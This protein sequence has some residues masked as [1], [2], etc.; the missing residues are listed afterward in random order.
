[1]EDKN[2]KYIFKEYYSVESN[3]LLGICKEKWNSYEG[4]REYL[5][6]TPQCYSSIDSIIINSDEYYSGTLLGFIVKIE[7]KCG[8]VNKE[9]DI[10][11]PIQYDSIAYY[12]NHSDFLHVLLDG[13][14]GVIT[15]DGT[16]IIPCLYDNIWKQS[17]NFF[18]VFANDK[19]GIYTVKGEL[20]MPVIYDDIE[21][22]S[23]NN[24]ESDD[25]YFIV[26][27]EGQYEIIKQDRTNYIPG[28]FDNCVLNYEL[29]ICTCKKGKWTL[30]DTKGNILIPFFDSIEEKNTWVRTSKSHPY[31]NYYKFYIDNNIGLF[32]CEKKEI[33][34]EAF[35]DNIEFKENGIIVSQNNKKGLYNFE[36]NEIVAP[37]FQS[38]EY[39]ANDYFI[40]QNE[41]KKGLVWFSKKKTLPCIYEEIEVY[42]HYDLYFTIISSG[43][44]GLIDSNLKI[45]LSAI[46]D[47]FIIDFHQVKIRIDN[48]WGLYNF[49][50]KRIV[51]PV[52]YSSIEN[53][54]SSSYVVVK[55]D[56]LIGIYSLSGNEKLPVI[57]HDIKVVNICYCCFYII[58]LD[59]QFGVLNSSMNLIVPCKYGNIEFYDRAFIIGENNNNKTIMDL[60]GNII[61]SDIIAFKEIYS[62]KNINSYYKDYLTKNINNKIGIIHHGLNTEKTIIPVNYIKAEIIESNNKNVFYKVLEDD[63]WGLFYVNT[64]YCNYSNKATYNINTE[65]V[66]P[67]KFNTIKHLPFSSSKEIEYFIVSE[68]CNYGV[69]EIII[70]ES[71]NC[72]IILPCKF[73][74]IRLLYDF[75]IAKRNQKYEIYNILGEKI[76]EQ[77]FNSINTIG[78]KYIIG[79]TDQIMGVYLNDGIELFSSYFDKIEEYGYS[80]L[81]GFKVQKYGLWGLKSLEGKDIIPPLYEDIKE[82]KDEYGNFLCHVAQ[83]KGQK[84]C[85]TKK[86]VKINDPAEV[87]EYINCHH[88]FKVKANG[89]WGLISYWKNSDSPTT[90][91]SPIYDSINFIIKDDNHKIIIVNKYNK[92]GLYLFTGREICPL[93]IDFIDE[94]T[95]RNY[96]LKIRSGNKYGIVSIIDEKLIVPIK[97]DKIRIDDYLYTSLNNLHGLYDFDGEEICPTIY[98]RIKLIGHEILVKKNNLWGVLNFLPELFENVEIHRLYAKLKINKFSNIKQI[99]W[100]QVQNKGEILFLFIYISTEKR[101]VVYNKEGIDINTPIFTD[102]I[103]ISNTIAL[104]INEKWGVFDYNFNQKIAPSYQTI[105][106]TFL[107]ID[108]G[109]I[110]K[111][112]DCIIVQDIHKK[113]G[114]INTNGNII[115]P[116]IYDYLVKGNSITEYYGRIDDNRYNLDKTGKLIATKKI[117]W[118]NLSLGYEYG[119]FE[120][121][122]NRKTL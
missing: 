120:D 38:I 49:D 67:C 58:R 102:F 115:I 113:Y 83:I 114:C 108:N 41:S 34:L 60:N 57:Y 103:F 96:F 81:H 51:I 121:D 45:I 6:I 65:V 14:W 116:F 74:E 4:K 21:I 97:Y 91:I 110:N 3:N 26:S 17:N 56:K 32:D 28:K 55:L 75:L 59:N 30:Y 72:K 93:T 73:E 54:I 100:E 64:L 119:I 68:N 13:K 85:Y 53:I 18:F 9:G 19:E 109:I 105:E 87:I 44:K 15:F 11:I 95:G 7:N 62:Y 82:F 61:E 37:F 1:M 117:S 2:Y 47:E 101:W 80:T 111:Y 46:Y 39:I 92:Y 20:I 40:I 50:E 35:Y 63:R 25:Y 94:W 106:T 23:L 52:H 24:G 48:K 99:N 16:S 10:I 89:L 76:I 27:T 107:K 71:L 90:I 77:E 31:D 70:N 78:Y 36:G 69:C 122:I 79:K 5:Y 84:V 66:F 118:N 43:K 29:G 86:G 104:K 42:Q 88:V 8:I 98:D 33:I 12:R 22:H 112:D